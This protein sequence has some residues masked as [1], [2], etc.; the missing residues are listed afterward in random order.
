MF[1]LEPML[2]LAYW[3]ALAGAA[4]GALAWLAWRRP[5]S[6]ARRPWR[7]LVALAGAGAAV[8]LVLLL[9]PMR[10]EPIPQPPG[11]PLLTILV[12]ATASMATPDMPGSRSRYQTAADWAA[13]LS[14]KAAPFEVRVATFDRTMKA[15]DVKEL[16]GR[17]PDGL[18]TD[19]A[20]VL[21][22]AT[23][24]QRPQ[25]QMV[26][27]LSDGIH[28]AG[29]TA[30]VL[31]AA[32][33]A[34]ALG[35]PIF[36]RSFG[37]DATAR[38]L[39]VE[40]R[41]PREIAFV[42]QKVPIAA[43]LLHRDL[44]GQSA[45]VRL[46][47]DG[48]TLE[49]RSVP[50][51]LA[52]G[53]EVRFEIQEPKTGMYRYEIV[54]DPLPG[55]TSLA[56]N[57][58]AVHL[59]VVDQPV[60]VLL[61]EG[62]PYW[63]SKFLAR[64]LTEDSSIELESVVRM[65]EGRLHRRTI[66]RPADA[67]QKVDESWEV[68][69]DF[70]KIVSSR[71]G[72]RSFQVVVLGRDAE[73]FL[74][75]GTLAELRTWLKQ[76]GGSLVCARGQPVAQVS[77]GLAPL[78][79]L[80]WTPATE[81]RVKWN[82]TDRGR[83]LGWLLGGTSLSG[84]PTLASAARPDQPRPLAVVL[85]TNAPPGEGPAPAVTYQPYGLGRV[86]TIEGSGMWRWAFLPPG[87]RDRDREQAFG[88]LWHNL[89][90]W[91]VSNAPL[92]PGQS[93]TLRLDAGS[94]SPEESIA[95]TLLV[96]PDSAKGPASGAPTVELSGDGIETRTLTAVPRSDEPGTLRVP[97]GKLPLGRYELRVPSEAAVRA[98]FD[99]RN[100]SRETLDLQARPDLMA[101][102]ARESGGAVLELPTADGVAVQLTEQLRRLRPEQVRRQSAWDRAWV[103]AAIAGL[104]GLTWVLRRRRNL[105]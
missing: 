53:E 13:K 98:V 69:P 47:R 49:E 71:G 1:S 105:L 43:S 3:L 104:W 11:P 4:V 30:D 31:K 86:V 37:S 2:P 80:R 88:S 46:L 97:I 9:N 99:V 16:A 102:I 60:R 48:K 25:G 27:L 87:E 96:R 12:D 6:V 93:M 79:P 26:A 8:V 68:L 72:L 81:T 73:A 51:K 54:A 75:Q 23:A 70:A 67:K 91:L 42:D 14:E 18:V 5:A 29:E 15:L 38:D 58:A 32:K 78:L 74:D 50:L 85:A 89:L 92:L 57:S 103:L 17:M 10:I 90:R 95:A 56:N 41:T 84:M 52:E 45:K 100:S 22:E 34:R 7:W 21:R 24:E 40:V 101:A 59:Q 63:D 36:V 39:A 61:L 77:Q 19:L 94:Y 65:T 82:L 33:D 66:R 64:T 44:T 83:D 20:T 35:C 55:E 62:K 28:N 76:D